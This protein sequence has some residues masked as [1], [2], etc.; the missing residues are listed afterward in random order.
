MFDGPMSY[1]TDEDVALRASADFGLICPRDQ[2]IASGDDGQFSPEDRWTLVSPSVDFGSFG[3][4]PGHVVLV[5]TAADFK[6]AEETFAVDR[7]AANSVTLRRKGQAAGFGQPP[8]PAGGQAQ[9]RFAA[10]TL[11]PQIASVSD[12][13]NRRYGIDD[14]ISGRRQ[15]DLFDPREVREAAVLMVLYRQYLELSRGQ[16]GRGDSFASKSQTYKQELDELLA[17][18]VVRWMTLPKAG[19]GGRPAG[20]FGTRLSR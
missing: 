16:E 2:K 10:L 18:T 1:A 11:G 3:L 4:G 9:A 20:R 7:V 19:A 13:L 15:C 8:A 14:L 6:S 12:E 17:R 5:T